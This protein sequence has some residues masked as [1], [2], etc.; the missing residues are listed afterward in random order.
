MVTTSVVLSN[1]TNYTQTI[2]PDIENIEE[3]N[4]KNENS[5]VEDVN[6]NNSQKQTVEPTKTSNQT[7]EIS[8]SEIMEV[9]HH[10]KVERKN[11][12]E[13]LLEGLMIFSLYH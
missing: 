12:K 10:P 13:Y 7:S 2:M 5:K 11:F 4:P 1:P 6:G 3:E 8:K 9:H